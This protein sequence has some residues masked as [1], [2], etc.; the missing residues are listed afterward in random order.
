MKEKELKDSY[1]VWMPL[2]LACFTA[3]GMVVGMRMSEESSIGFFSDNSEALH[4]EKDYYRLNEIFKFIDAKYID[5]IDKHNLLDTLTE[6][7]FSQLDPYSKYIPQDKIITQREQILGYYD[8]MGVDAI[9][10][11]DSLIVVNVMENSPS[12][13]A[14]VSIGD[15]IIS[16]NDIKI[17]GVDMSFGEAFQVIRSNAQKPM[18]LKVKNLDKAYSYK[19]IYPG[20]IKVENIIHA[21]VDGALY[22]RINQFSKNTFEEFLKTLDQY[23]KNNTIEKLILDL[24]D[25]TGGFMPEATKILCQIFVEDKRLL[26]STKDRIGREKTYETTGRPF[27]K[28]E[29]VAVLINGRTA[30]ASEIIA[31]AIQE[32]ERGVIIGEPSYGKGLVQEEFAL[33]NKGIVRLTTKK[34]YT[35]N[36]RNLQRLN[37]N[38]DVTQLDTTYTLITKKPLITENGRLWP[39]IM[40]SYLPRQIQVLNFFVTHDI[41]GAAFL[42]LEKYGY[43]NK[44]RM[45]DKLQLEKDVDEYIRNIFTDPDNPDIFGNTEYDLARNIFMERLYEMHNMSQEEVHENAKYDRDIQAA[46]KYFRTAK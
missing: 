29:D 34:Y 8:G 1:K 37:D 12:S 41:R 36:G 26:V 30:S 11:N 7:L 43:Y 25:N 5:S 40:T 20:K 23:K 16:C 45:K 10:R 13:E 33:K 22:F 46:L 35:P 19:T 6:K 28:I 32:W 44:E 2:L 27:Y 38:T 3:L 14:N 21:E 4:I 17:S 39:D 18:R 31:A 15:R 9:F 24:R 42:F